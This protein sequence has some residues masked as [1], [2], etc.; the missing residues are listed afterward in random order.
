MS[1]NEEMNQEKEDLTSQNV[2]QKTENPNIQNMGQKNEKP[3]TMKAS[4]KINQETSDVSKPGKKNCCISKKTCI[5]IA[6]V[7]L[8]LAANSVFVYLIVVHKLL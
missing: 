5:G 7:L 4:Q 1:Y 2:G 6:C 3:M 8:L